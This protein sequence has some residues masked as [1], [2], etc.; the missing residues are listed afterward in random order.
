MLEKQDSPFP[1]TQWALK[2]NVHVAGDVCLKLDD[3]TQS[4]TVILQLENSES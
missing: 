4:G 2:G 1:V 3:K